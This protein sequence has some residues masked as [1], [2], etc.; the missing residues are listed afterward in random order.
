M[1]DA[2]KVGSGENLSSASGQPENER[3]GSNEF[4][5]TTGSYP[6]TM[7]KHPHRT[8]GGFIF[9]KLK[10]FYDY[11]WH[12]YRWAPTRVATR[13][14]W[15]DNG[16]EYLKEFTSTGMWSLDVDAPIPQRMAAGLGLGLKASIFIYA[17]NY[18]NLRT[19]YQIPANAAIFRALRPCA[20]FTASCLIYC[21]SWPVVRAL[22]GYSQTELGRD[23]DAALAGALSGVI[24]TAM[25]IRNSRFVG[26]SIPV[27]YILGG[28]SVG[29]Y[30]AA[31]SGYMTNR[32]VHG[33]W[34]D[35]HHW[36]RGNPL[37]GP[38]YEDRLARF[39]AQLQNAKYKEYI[40]TSV[41]TRW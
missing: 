41:R 21:G 29:L 33:G 14:F 35:I 13:F 32:S 15:S 17:I 27:A 40:D 11:Y 7:P 36:R 16:W 12:Y 22:R 30:N 37:Y 20:F 18:R 5:N 34:S 10:D 23:I 38:P 4:T 31:H 3:F 28:M 24:I 39:K 6:V 26:V 8:G 2:K 1:P 25:W 19:R 9:E